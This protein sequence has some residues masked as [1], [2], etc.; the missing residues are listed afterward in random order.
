M[1]RTTR[2]TARQLIAL[3]ASAALLTLSGC[4]GSDVSDASNESGAP[5]EPVTLTILAHESFTPSEGIFDSFTEA[6][7]ITVEIATSADAGTLLAKASLTAGNPEGDVLWGVDNTLLSRAID[8]DVFEPYASSLLD[9]LPDDLLDLVPG[10]E[11]TPVDTG[12][13]CINYDIAAL[14]ELGVD[15]PTSFT[16]LTE[17]AYEDLLV[18]PSPASS[19]PG[20]AFLM[21]TIAE[22]GDGWTDYWAALRGNGVEVVDGWSEAYHGSFTRAGGDRP[23]V[24]SYASSPPFEVLFADPP[25]EADAPAPTGVVTSTCLRQVEFAGVLRGTDHPEEAGKLIDFLIDT[26]FQSDILLTQ[27]VDPVNP[28]AAIPAL[29]TQYAVVPETSLSLDPTLIEAERSE[30]IDEWTTIV[31]R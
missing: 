9:Q 29:Y 15:P 11:A 13:V 24:V 20:L 12:D 14:D 2:T 16:D 27:F 26:E 18:V 7:G 17:P 30:W 10:N 25:L 5:A 22:L 1:T 21:A 3:G 23:L 6:T 28:A 31:L 4:G 8:D 19:S